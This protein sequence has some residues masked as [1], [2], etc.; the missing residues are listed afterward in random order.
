MSANGSNTNSNLRQ[1]RRTVGKK[2]KKDYLYFGHK[3][4]DEKKDL[5]SNF[6]D[7]T[8]DSKLDYDTGE[9]HS[10]KFKK[11]FIAALVILVLFALLF[12][13]YIN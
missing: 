5:Q 12:L 4:F 11:Q 9:Y 1:L 8:I 10:L 6:K 2:K 13:M 7:E 3:M